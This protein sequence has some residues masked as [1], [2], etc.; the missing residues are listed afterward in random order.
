MSRSQLDLLEIARQEAAGNAFAHLSRLSMFRPTN[1][2]PSGFEDAVIWCGGNHDDSVNPIT[3]SLTDKFALIGTIEVMDL[4]GLPFYAVPMMAQYRHD[5]KLAPLAWFGNMPGTLVKWSTAGDAMVNDGNGGKVVVAGKSGN[6]QLRTAAGVFCNVRPYG[7]ITSVRCMPCLP[8]SQDKKKFDVNPTTGIV[9]SEMNSPGPQ[10]AYACRHFL[11]LVHETGQMGRVALKPTQ[12]QEDGIIAGLLYWLLEGTKFNI[13]KKYEVD[14]YQEQK[15]QIDKIIAL[16]PTD[17]R[18]GM[19]EWGGE[20][21]M[22]IADTNYGLLLHDTIDQKPTIVLAT[23]LDG[24][25]L[26]DLMADCPA[27]L[28]KMCAKVLAH[29]AVD[30]EVN[31]LW[32]DMGFTSTDGRDMTSVM[33]R[34]TG[35]PIY[36]QTLGSA[37]AMLNRLLAGNEGN[38]YNP[39]IHFV[40]IRDA[41]IAANPTNSKLHR[42]LDEQ[43]AIFDRVYASKPGFVQG[44]QALCEAMTPWSAN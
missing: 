14:P 30:Y 38:P 21:S 7:G 26:T 23:D 19:Q 37:D 6:A 11:R 18:A 20:I 40:L 13:K 2:R 4:L 34:M 43:L 29:L 9:H 24:D 42:W 1:L 22:H 15:P 5:M 8:Y 32:K 10:M 27:A 39:R 16:L 28:R 3:H 33:H 41:Y 25:R 36:E 31:Q 12:A 44:Y 35:D 17:F